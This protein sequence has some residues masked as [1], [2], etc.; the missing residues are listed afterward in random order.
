MNRGMN[1]LR[2]VGICAAIIAAAVGITG[3]ATQARVPATYKDAIERIAQPNVNSV[4]LVKPPTKSLAKTS[5][6]IDSITANLAIGDTI[7][8]TGMNAIYLGSV[9]DSGISERYAAFGV[10]AT[11]GGTAEFDYVKLTPHS[12]LGSYNEAVMTKNGNGTFSEFTLKLDTLTITDTTCTATLAYPALQPVVDSNVW[13]AFSR[14][15]LVSG[16][17]VTVQG[18][19]VAV[20]NFQTR[21][22]GLSVT[23]SLQNTDVG[24]ITSTLAEGESIYYNGARYGIESIGAISG[25]AYFAN[26]AAYAERDTLIYLNGL[27]N[28]MAHVSF[29]PDLKSASVNFTDTSGD[30]PVVYNGQTFSAIILAVDGANNVK[31]VTVNGDTYTL[32]ITDAGVTITPVSMVV[33]RHRAVPMNATTFMTQ[34]GNMLRFQ[35]ADNGRHTMEVYGMTG[36][37]MDSFQAM[38]GQGISTKELGLRSG[39]YLL[40]EKGSSHALKFQVQ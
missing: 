31:T 38:S 16:P 10:Q 5:T 25:G 4:N 1:N 26:M 9:V 14:V 28:C 34:R 27:T 22:G 29:T 39:V 7:A 19:V 40:K 17:P 15:S 35:F 30:V 36:K 13:N 6:A 3:Q 20:Q 24:W 37:R 32:T 23:I 2:R 21:G 11:N 12:S 8:V 33:P 18:N